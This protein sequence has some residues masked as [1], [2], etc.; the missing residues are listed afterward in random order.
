[1]VCVC[2]WQE[3]VRALIESAGKSELVLP[4]LRKA[5]EE[6]GT[7][8]AL[9]AEYCAR[10]QL[11][12]DEI[13]QIEQLN[14][15]LNIQTANQQRLL[16]ELDSILVRLHLFYLDLAPLTCPRCNPA[17][18]ARISVAESQIR[19]LCEA[20]LTD[21]GRID[22]MLVALG[23]LHTAMQ[24]KFE[25]GLGSLA[26]VVERMVYYGTVMKSFVERM[27]AFF[28]GTF[29]SHVR[30]AKGRGTLQIVPDSCIR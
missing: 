21:P 6:V 11:M 28:I 16:A 25:D 24:G 12:G 9:L 30:T 7:V 10:L 1:M 20:P 26:A 19:V 4:S 29:T 3:N 2:G 17:F 22:E 18:Q 27:V 23:T 13:R 5:L 14:R 15:G 8:D